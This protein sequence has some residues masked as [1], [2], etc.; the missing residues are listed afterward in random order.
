MWDV[1]APIVR[2]PLYS[3]RR[4]IGV[5]IVAFVAVFMVGEIN[6]GSRQN[7]AAPGPASPRVALARPSPMALATPAAVASGDASSATDAL[8]VDPAD[9]DPSAA[10]ADSA[11]A[12]VAAWARPDLDGNAWAAG[13]RPLVTTEL[14]SAGLKMTVP[15]S[16]P[17]VTVRGEPRQVAMNPKGGVFDVPT[18]GPWVRVHVVHAPAE[19]KWLV[20]DV[21][22][23]G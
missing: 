20:S 11:A 23:V 19:G 21:E 22:P 6:D 8:S 1:L 3:P 14:W 5:V 18:T 10:A 7:V 9:E 17:A 15:S 2:W 16:T 4:F 13:V 12:F